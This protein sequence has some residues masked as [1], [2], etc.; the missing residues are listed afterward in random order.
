VTDDEGF[1]RAVVDSPGDDTPRLVYADWLDDRA[2]PRGPYLRA[3]ME[4]AKPWRSGER[5]ADSP[6]LW[7]LARGLD[8][9]WVARVTRPPLGVCCDARQ[10]AFVGPVLS[11]ADV[12]RFEAEIGLSLIPDYRA[13][14]LNMNGGIPVATTDE[15]TDP[16][17]PTHCVYS[18]DF[19]GQVSDR[20]SLLS[21][22]RRF[23]S[24]LPSL[25]SEELWGAEPGDE[26]WFADSLPIGDS[27]KDF[28]LFYAVRG[29]YAG[30]LH[31]HDYTGE[32][33]R[34]GWLAGSHGPP[35]LP[36]FLHCIPQSGWGLAETYPSQPLQEFWKR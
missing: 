14:L 6:E 15:T 20:R 32:W 34:F 1:I 36:E 22:A 17:S 4:W 35:T 23:R 29:K 9:V 21:H 5:P 16:V 18:L 12:N 27:G 25:A 7:E 26:P 33:C 31:L 3:E 11:E 30:H 13:F 8:P 2:D 10:F 24:W 28:T 19:H